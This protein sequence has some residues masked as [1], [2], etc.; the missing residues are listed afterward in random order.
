MEAAGL[1]K[2]YGVDSSGHPTDYNIH[3][4]GCTG[5]EETQIRM[6]LDVVAPPGGRPTNYNNTEKGWKDGDHG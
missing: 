2:E 6:G 5:K 4:R 3:S 1:S